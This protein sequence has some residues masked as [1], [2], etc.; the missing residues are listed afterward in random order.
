MDKICTV[1][2]VD[3]KFPYSRHLV[4]RAHCTLGIHLRKG[5]TLA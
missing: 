2:L 4:E 1:Y 5:T 3:K